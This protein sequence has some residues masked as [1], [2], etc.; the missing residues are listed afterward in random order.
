MYGIDTS[1]DS[2]LT[3]NPSNGSVTATVA[4]DYDAANEL[5]MDFDET[6][7]TPILYVTTYNNGSGHD[8]LR[9]IDTTTGTTTWVGDFPAGT[10]LDALAFTSKTVYTE[11]TVILP[12]GGE[13]LPAGYIID[14]VEWGAPEEAVEFKLQFSCDYGNTWKKIT[15]KNLTGLTELK[16]LWLTKVPKKDLTD[17]L[18]RVIGYNAAR[19]EIG[20]DTSDAIFTIATSELL[21]PVPGIT[22]FE[23]GSVNITWVTYSTQA[24]VDKVRV[25]YSLD[26]GQT[27]I[28]AGKTN[29]NPEAFLWTVPN[30]L[31]G[32]YDQAWIQILLK[33]KRENTIG[34]STIGPFTILAF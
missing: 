8:E 4:L 1:T 15:K 28:S 22:V 31:P 17:C 24:R 9:I 21:S 25:N 30:I 5:G 11:V 20:R 19:E 7:G 34:R 12:N 3:I 23:G 14:S 26:G 33:D 13:I 27:W 29:G 2:L 16:Y 6:S 10:R 18:V 32:T